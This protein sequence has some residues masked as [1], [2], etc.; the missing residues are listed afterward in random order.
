LV[1]LLRDQDQPKPARHSNPPTAYIRVA[2]AQASQVE[3]SDFNFVTGIMGNQ[4]QDVGNQP[5][6]PG[7]QGTQSAQQPS[8]P[9]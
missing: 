6:R 3:V 5:N 4:S 7:R 8:R 9:D 2:R 1:L